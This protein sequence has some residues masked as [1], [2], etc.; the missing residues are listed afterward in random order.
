MCVINF[1]SWYG[2][3]TVLYNILIV[4]Y[5]ILIY[6]RCIRIIG[7][8]NTLIVE[9]VIVIP[10]LWLKHKRLYNTLIVKYIIASEK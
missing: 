6:T 2:L 7:L 1:Y 8:Y 3:N 5:I 9:Y 4:K 10:I